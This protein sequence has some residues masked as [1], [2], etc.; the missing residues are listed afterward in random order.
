MLA[1]AS[2]ELTPSILHLRAPT[3]R[4]VARCE[5]TRHERAP[6]SAATP[7][8]AGSAL[9]LGMQWIEEVSRR[10]PKLYPPPGFVVASRGL[11]ERAEHRMGFPSKV[12]PRLDSRIYALEEPLGAIAWRVGRALSRWSLSCRER[13]I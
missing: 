2:R 6:L 4:A 9:R 8:L 7:A 3:A 12:S 13:S 1:A 10:R 11:I 5:A